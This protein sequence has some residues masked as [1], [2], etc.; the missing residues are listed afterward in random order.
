VGCIFNSVGLIIT[1]VW[2]FFPDFFP[3]PISHFPHFATSFFFFV[4]FNFCINPWVLTLLHYSFSVS[5]DH[6]LP[7]LLVFFSFCSFAT[8]SVVFIFVLF[9]SLLQHFFFK[10]VFFTAFSTLLSHLHFFQLSGE[11]VTA[12]NLQNCTIR[13]QIGKSMVHWVLL[14]INESNSSGL[15]RFVS[16]P[17]TPQSIIFDEATFLNQIRP[18]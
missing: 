7:H 13:C 12:V 16:C 10:S 15:N 11:A 9:P 4:F 1:L 14:I 3:C 17:D 18:G 5:S 8:C 6:S 2:I